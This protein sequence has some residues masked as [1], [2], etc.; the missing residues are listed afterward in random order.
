MVAQLKSDVMCFWTL[1]RGTKCDCFSQEDTKETT[2]LFQR[3]APELFLML[4][5]THTLNQRFQPKIFPIHISDY[6]KLTGG[7]VL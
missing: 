5:L 1:E 6:K 2:G 4:Q 7:K 3:R